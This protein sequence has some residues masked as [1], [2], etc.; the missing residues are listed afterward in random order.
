MKTIL[1]VDD[2]HIMRNIVKNT[3]NLLKIPCN[4]LESGDG[5]AALKILLSTPVD[6]V[7]LDWNMPGLS[8]IDFLKKVRAMEQYKNIPIVMVTSEAAKLN[9]I[10]A[11]KAGA[12]AYITK[13]ID[14]KIF[15]DKIEKISF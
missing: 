8:G 10:E 11:I 5:D 13:P 3:F 9:I 7:L 4:Y 2:S 15:M 12:T 1:V 14:T 6:M